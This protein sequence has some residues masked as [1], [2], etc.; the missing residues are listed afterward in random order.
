MPS[1]SHRQIVLAYQVNV[2]KYPRADEHWDHPINST[3]HCVGH[4]IVILFVKVVAV[5]EQMKEM[6]KFF[7]L[8]IVFPN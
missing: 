1:L 4:K 7:H 6:S 2:A 5:L 8:L 3:V